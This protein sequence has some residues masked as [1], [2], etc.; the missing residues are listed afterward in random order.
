MRILGI[1]PA[2]YA[3][4]RFPGK[5]LAL[6]AGKPLVQWVAEQ[7]RQAKSL[8]ELVVATDDARI[9]EVV[10]GFCR[11]EMTRTDHPSGSDR[12]AEVASRCQ[13][14]AIVNIQ[15]DEPLIEPAVIDAVAGALARAE[16][17]TAATAI[18]NPD[19][20]DNPNVVKV[21]VNAAGR[22]LYFSRRTIP[23]LREAASRSANEQLAAFPFLKH[24]GIY[25]Y[26]RE[27][28][29]RLVQFP[30]SPLEQAEKLEQLRA[31]ENGIEIAV[32]KVDYDSVGVDV[33]EDVAQVEKI[34][35]V[36]SVK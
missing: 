15:G 4:T 33:P 8:S 14:D 24:L 16:M 13:C 2:R 29:L 18:R 12:I 10:R 11:V 28:L 6:I 5:P 19:E 21:V 9:A 30:M 17:S 26:R 20:Y 7:C 31:L 36:K 25:G 32:V 27:T 35:R 22:A 23:Y 1:I 3:S 34:L